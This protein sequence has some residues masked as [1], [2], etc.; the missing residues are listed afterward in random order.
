MSTP[1]T[2]YSHSPQVELQPVPVEAVTLDDRF[3]KP[4]CDLNRT[5]TLR[6]QLEHCEST[7]RI[8]NFRRASGKKDVPFQGLVFN[9]SDVYKVIEAIAFSLASHPDPALESDLDA[10]IAEIADAQGPDGYLNTYFMFEKAEERWT[11]LRDLHEMYCTGHLI[12]AAVAHFR[13]TGKRTLLEVALKLADHLYEMFGPDG[14]EGACGHPEVEMALIEL[15]RTVGDAKYTQLAKRMIELRGKTPSVID[16]HNDFDRRSIQD[17]E[18]YEALM[19]VTGHAVRMLYLA[20]GATD[21]LAEEANWGG[22]FFSA[23]YHQ[24][25][26]FTERRMYVTGGAGSRYEGEAFGKDYELPNDRA[27][28]ETCAAIASVMWNWRLHHYCYGHGAKGR[29]TD[30]RGDGTQFTDLIEHTLY[31]AVLPGLSLDGKHYFYQNPLAD[32]GTHQ[33][34]EWFGCACCPPNLARTLAMLPGYFY[35]AFS[36]G[37]AVHLYAQGTAS[38]PLPNG[39]VLNLKQ[40]TEYPW[41]GEIE[42]EV[43]PDSSENTLLSLRIPAWA[44]GASLTRNGSESTAPEPGSYHEVTGLNPGDRLDLHLPMPVRKLT[45][46]S[47]L[48]SNR[49]QIALQRGPMVYCVENTDHAADVRDLVLPQ[50]LELAAEHRPELLGGVTVLKGVALTQTQK[51]G[52]RP[53]YTAEPKPPVLSSVSLT[54]IPYYAWAN[55]EPGAMCVWLSQA[56]SS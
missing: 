37:A 2:D 6:A 44:D 25:E 14:R 42:L 1:I 20:C 43:L 39:G 41:S 17:H 49:G 28:T 38:I 5:V 45:S 52:E 34:Q 51:S 4:R 15:S 9:D 53:L 23:I 7:G 48:V 27:Y 19:E 26:N 46:H 36:G 16:G 3:W 31:N 56:Q 54:A 24:W 12:Q 35:S 47:R 29:D 21:L 10:V 11:N 8:D 33:R 32:D 22:S 50:A 40:T 18:P 55:R 30:K 13:A